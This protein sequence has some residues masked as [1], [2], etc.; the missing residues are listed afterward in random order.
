V[1]LP[2]QA[3]TVLREIVEGKRP[4][5]LVFTTIQGRR[6]QAQHFRERVWH[7]AVVR[8]DLGKSPRVHDLR[9]SHATW[10][11]ARGMNLAMLQRRLGHEK[12]TTTV[13][14]YGH[15]LPDALNKAADIASLSLAGALLQIEG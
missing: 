14:T 3:V 7:P 1:S 13:D 12:I 15:V 9:H 6:V 2:E 8:A 11:I 4:D 5:D 10:M